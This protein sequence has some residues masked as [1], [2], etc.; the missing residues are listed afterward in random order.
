MTEAEARAALAAFDGIGGLERWI[1][2]QRPWEAAPRGLR[3]QAQVRVQRGQ[4]QRL[5]FEQ[6]A[7]RD[8]ALDQDLSALVPNLTA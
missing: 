4:P 8:D 3:V 5:E 2:E 1:A 6:P 7:D